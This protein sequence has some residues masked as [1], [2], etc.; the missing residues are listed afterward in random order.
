MRAYQ[1]SATVKGNML[2]ASGFNSPIILAKE[3]EQRFNAALD[4]IPVPAEI[5]GMRFLRS[6]GGAIH[7]RFWRRPLAALEVCCSAVR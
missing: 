1:D 4:V 2:Q 6:E 3:K 7:A 5:I